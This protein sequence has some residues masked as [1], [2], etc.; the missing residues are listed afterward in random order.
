MKKVSFL[1]LILLLLSTTVLTAQELKIQGTVVDKMNKE[2]L[3]GA[4]VLQKGTTNGTITN[5]DG[6]FSINV[7]A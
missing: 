5:Y 1:I 3:I 7:L 4:T 2:S 6:V